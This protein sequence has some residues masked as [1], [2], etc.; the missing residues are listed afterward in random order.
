MEDNSKKSKRIAKNTGILYLRMI[1]LM[2]ITLYTSRVILEALGVEDYG[3]YNVVGGFVA[4][5]GVLSRSMTSAS[6]RFINYEIGKG[7]FDRLQRVFNATFTIMCLIAMVIAVLSEVLGIWYV[8]NIMVIKPERLYAANWVFQ[9]SVITFCST[10]ITVPY[11]AAII[12]HEHM[13]T[14]AYVSLFEGIAKLAIAFAVMISPIDTLIFYAAA[15]CILQLIIQGMYRQYC[16]KHF[17]ECNSRLCYDR[18]IVKDIFGYAGWTFFGTSAALL[19]N[20][21]GNM[22][23]NYFFGPVVNAARGVANQVLHAVQG[24]VTNFTLAL[25]PQITQNYANG[26][27]D[28]M[29]KLV[30]AG[31]RMS[32]YMLLVLSL[33][34]IINADYILHIWLKQVPETAVI[35]TQLTLIF[36]MVESLSHTLIKAQQ[37]TGQIKKFQLTMSALMIMNL[38]ISFAIYKLEGRPESFLIVAIIISIVCLFVRMLLLRTYV[39]LNF[40]DFLRKVFFNVLAVTALAVSLPCVMSHYTPQTF[41]YVLLNV[42]L[43]FLTSIIA[44]LFV[45]CTASERIVVSNYA[46]KMIKRIKK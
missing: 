1:F 16:R 36:T 6:T 23:I 29:M 14:F 46:K 18:D 2:L 24:F 28:Y 42:V 34:I 30:Y 40:L 4:L 43:S 5:F 20:Q 25:D 3:V 9:F 33:P 19:R 13:K 39:K 12:A 11:N 45:G 35:F 15:V 32:Y 37:A 22:I 26:N 17:T 7:N 31:S 44:I 41:G 8:N 21:G 38:P 10:L 27:H